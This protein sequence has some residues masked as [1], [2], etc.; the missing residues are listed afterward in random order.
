MKLMWS[1]FEGLLKKAL[2]L[3]GRLGRRVSDLGIRDTESETRKL[4]P[5]VS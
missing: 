4:K 3:V 2:K 5:Q 1:K